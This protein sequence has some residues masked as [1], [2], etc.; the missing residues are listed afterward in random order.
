MGD[1]SK[2]VCLVRALGGSYAPSSDSV[3]GAGRLPKAGLLRQWQAL[4]FPVEAVKRAR[5]GEHGSVRGLQR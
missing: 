2:S 5:G 4:D 1:G 3:P